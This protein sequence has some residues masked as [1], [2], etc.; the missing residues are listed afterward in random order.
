M[1]AF[2]FCSPLKAREALSQDLCN[3]CSSTT[4][5][6]LELSEN[7]TAGARK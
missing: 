6:E 1:H 3:P 5:K 2:V 7:K 4:Q